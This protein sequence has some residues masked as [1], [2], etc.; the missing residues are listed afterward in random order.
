MPRQTTDTPSASAPA[1]GTLAAIIGHTVNPDLDK[2]AG[3]FLLVG[4][5]DADRLGRLVGAGAGHVH[6]GARLVELRVH[7]AVGRVQ[8]Q[9]LLAQQ[10]LSRSQAGGDVGVGPTLV[11]DHVFDPPLARRRVEGVLVDLESAQPRRRRRRRIVH[12]R[13][14]RRDGLLVRRRDRVVWVPCPAAARR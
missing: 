9:Q 3:V 10:L 1:P 7:V 11:G 4:A 2:D 13:H 6:L 14:V 5:G 12:P 8:G